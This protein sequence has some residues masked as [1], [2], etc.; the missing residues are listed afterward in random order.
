MPSHDP[1]KVHVWYLG[2]LNVELNLI[3]PQNSSIALIGLGRWM[4]H[5]PAD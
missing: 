1:E 5:Q 3:G 4:E 2:A